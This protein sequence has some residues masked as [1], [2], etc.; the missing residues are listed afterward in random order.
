MINK[1]PFIAILGLCVAAQSFSFGIDPSYSGGFVGSVTSPYGDSVNLKAPPAEELPTTSAAD[2]CAN[3]LTGFG[4][5]VNRGSTIS[6]T[7]TI[8]VYKA[9]TRYNSS[10]NLYNLGVDFEGRLNS[11]EGLDANTRWVLFYDSHV[12]TFEY[13]G[14]LYEGSGPFFYNSTD[15]AFNTNRSNSYGS[16]TKHIS[17]IVDTRVG[18]AS[19]PP[20]SVDTD[21]YA[22]LVGVS[23]N[24]LTIR[25][26][27]HFGYT[28]QQ[29]PVPEPVSCA[30]LAIG[31]LFLLRRR[32][33]R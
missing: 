7:M 18:N 13:Q 22:F 26:G 33:A 31:S 23:G 5:T 20:Y 10:L 19:S 1:R 6:G 11:T 24:N 17:E 28:G 2:L 15:E 27:V 29:V 12:S 16:F 14:L 30:T 3:A 8:D 21:Y 4:Y 9:Y 32:K 25:D